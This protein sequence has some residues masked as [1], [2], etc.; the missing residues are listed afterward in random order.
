MCA[1]VAG[2]AEDL[3][4][5]ALQL[6]HGA[7]ETPIRRAGRTRETFGGGVPDVLRAVV[8]ESAP[9]G[10]TKVAVVGARV[11]PV[12]SGITSRSTG[13]STTSSAR[14]STVA[15]IRA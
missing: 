3:S 7:V 8:G 9:E 5:V 14:A 4:E 2:R 6:V 13:S 12:P 15:P 1:S 11:I 10:H